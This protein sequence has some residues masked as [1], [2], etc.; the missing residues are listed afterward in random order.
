MGQEGEVQEGE[1]TAA[2]LGNSAGLKCISNC[3]CIASV[4]PLLAASAFFYG[5]GAHKTFTPSTF[6]FLLP[7]FVKKFYFTFICLARN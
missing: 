2:S 5:V 4:S 6:K 3:S 7:L 1:S